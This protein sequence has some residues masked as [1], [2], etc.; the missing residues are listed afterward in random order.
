VE[1][2]EIPLY[3][4]GIPDASMFVMAAVM[5]AEFLFNV[6]GI[7]FRLTSCVVSFTSATQG[8]SSLSGNV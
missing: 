6:S 2:S 8:A 4:S 1:A 7:C 5:K 3:Y